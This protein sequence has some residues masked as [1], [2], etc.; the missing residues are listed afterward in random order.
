MVYSNIVRKDELRKVQLKALK[1]LSDALL[2]SF[3]PMGSNTLIIKDGVLNRYTKDGYSILKEIKLS[4]VIEHSITEDLVEVTRKIAGDFGD[5]TTSAVLMAYLLFKEFVDREEN[6]GELPFSIIENFKKAATA[7]SKEIEKHCMECTTDKIW[8]IAYTSTNG[9]KD[10]ADMLKKVYEEYG[11]DVFIDVGISNTGYDMIEEFDG[12]TIDTGYSDTAYINDVEKG[13]CDLRNPKIYIFED[14]V[15]TPEMMAFMDAILE[16]NI[17]R[18]MHE[19]RYEDVVPTVIMATK[20]SRDMS[21]YLEQL[22]NYLMSQKAANK[23]PVLILNDIVQKE[24]MLDI[25]KLCGCKLICKYINAAAQKKDIEAGLAPTL[26][27]VTTFGGTA[28]AVVSGVTYTKFVNPANMYDKEGNPTDEYSNLVTWLEAQLEKAVKE[29]QDHNYTGTLRRRINSLKSNMVE[30]MIGGASAGDRDSKRDLVEDAVLNCRSAAAHGVGHGANFEGLRASTDLVS[31]K[32]FNDEIVWEYINIIR[33]AYSEV[34]KTLYKTI[35]MTD[36]DANDAISSSLHI[37]AND[38][39][40]GPMNLRTREFDGRVLTSIKSDIITLEVLS[41]ILTLMI[42]AN[43]A[44]L[45]NP[46]VNTYYGDERV[47]KGLVD[48]NQNFDM[49]EPV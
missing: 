12:M 21:A 48:E 29:G 15:D 30:I 2:N 47:K 1:E 35:G 7:I 34:S 46:L 14:P 27:T 33:V 45:Q 41:K 32:L 8:D 3:G 11:M 16:Q 4:G 9:N 49:A 40:N 28:E 19:G 22:I 38:A 37:K 31:H 5:N 6:G 23:I 20:I 43:Q 39:V 42:T 18:P 36:S 44:L 13:V 17:M 26:A 24:R 10:I 25:A